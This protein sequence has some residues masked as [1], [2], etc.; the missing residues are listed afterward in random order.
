MRIFETMRTLILTP[1]I[2]FA[3][4]SLADIGIDVVLVGS[5]DLGYEASGVGLQFDTDGRFGEWGWDGQATF[6]KHAKRGA[7]GERY[8][9]VFMARRFFNNFF[10]E[11]G[12][13]Y[14]GYDSRF[15]NGTKWT[16]YGAAPGIGFGQHLSNREVTIR[17]FFPD[18]TP[19]NTSVFQVAGEVHLTRNITL[20]GSFEQWYFDQSGQRLDGTQ[21]TLE[22]GYRW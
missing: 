19:N 7:E 18:S 22:V 15:E 20:G 11:A 9:G 3:P 4:L 13:E 21:V 10:V 16:K 6:L 5:S 17:Y 2:F 1:F 14:G 8:Q 12:A